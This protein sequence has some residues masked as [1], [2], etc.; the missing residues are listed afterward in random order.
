[1]AY[2]GEQVRRERAAEQPVIDQAEAVRCPFCGAEAG[3]H[4]QTVRGRAPGS[5]LRTFH[6]VRLT[7]SIDRELRGDG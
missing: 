1:M 7:A 2:A 5:W 3:S 4:C 6:A